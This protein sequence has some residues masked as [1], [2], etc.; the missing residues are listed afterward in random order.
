MSCETET[1]IIGEHEYSVT[2]WPAKKAILTKFKLIKT[3]GASL[4]ILAGQSS[5]EDYDDART[6]SDGLSTL[7]NHSSPDELLSLMTEC[8][9]GVAC[10]GKRITESRFD[11]I[12]SGDNLMD[13][14]KVFIFVLKVN[15]GNLMKG[16]LADRFLAKMKENL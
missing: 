5:N 12:F 14:Y 11:E 2:Q 1:K 8:V 9:I 13:V 3:F 6:L 15:Y 16:Q 7:F 4:A 10:D